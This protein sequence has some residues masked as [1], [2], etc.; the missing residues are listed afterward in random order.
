MTIQEYLKNNNLTVSEL[1]STTEQS[2]QTLNN[3]YNNPKKKTVF[4]LIVLGVIAL[5]RC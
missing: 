2:R 5:N 4:E 1:A 3:W